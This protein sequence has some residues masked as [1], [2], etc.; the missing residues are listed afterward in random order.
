[1]VPSGLNP[2]T[3]LANARIGF[4]SP[5]DSLRFMRR[6]KS[7][8]VMGL[9]PYL[10][11]FCLYLAFVGRYVSPLLT[12]FLI[13]KDILSHAAE[14]WF[15]IV[16][17]LIWFLALMVFALLGPAVVNT[18]AS[19]L[20]DLIAAKTYETERKVTLPETRL[21][22]FIR[23][24]IGECSKAALWVMVTF[25]LAATPFATI[26]GGPLAIWFMGW[27]HVDRTLNLK[28]M[29]L[30]ERLIFGLVNAP[31]CMALGLWALVPVVNT[32]CT[33]LMASAGAIVVAKTE[34]IDN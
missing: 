9:A 13:E 26:L 16:E 24:F 25:L 27:T 19:P 29:H 11:A 3:L 18:L 30:K 10:V 15:G 32:V 17:V 12:G 33:F 4:L 22:Q 21:E 31:A 5:L 8:L 20:Y 34:Q 2:Q 14:G 28:S 7:L 23:S 6:K 1:M